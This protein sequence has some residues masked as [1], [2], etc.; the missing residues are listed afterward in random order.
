MGKFS[1]TLHI[2]NNVDESVNKSLD[3]FKGIWYYS[4]IQ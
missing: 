3:K 2:K 4:A 1:A